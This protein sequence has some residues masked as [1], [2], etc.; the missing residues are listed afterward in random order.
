MTHSLLPKHAALALAAFFCAAAGGMAWADGEFYQVDVSPTTEGGV[1]TIERGRMA[2]GLGYSGYAGGADLNLSASYKLSVGG[3]ELPI[4]LRI[5]PALQRE[6]LEDWKYGLRLV[7]EHYRP[8]GFGHLFLLGEV[9]TI[10]RGYFGLVQVGLSDASVSV[11]LTH[12]GDDDGFEESAIAV[13]RPLAG[14]KASLRL[15]YKL[16]EGVAFVGWSYNTF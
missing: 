12:Q 11:E 6:R 13:T 10:D 2:Y 16:R 3:P 4:T 15:G 1:A 9:T 8:T 5:G 14:S 7:A